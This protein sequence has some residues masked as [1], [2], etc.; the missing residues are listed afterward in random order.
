MIQTN[1][2]YRKTN[3]NPLQLYRNFLKKDP[4]L[5]NLLQTTDYCVVPLRA[6]N[7]NTTDLVLFWRKNGY[8]FVSLH[9]QIIQ[10]SPATAQFRTANWPIWIVQCFLT[11]QDS[12]N[13]ITL[14]NGILSYETNVT[15]Q[16]FR[17][18]GFTLARDHRV[19][20]IWATC[21][22]SLHPHF[23]KVRSIEVMDM[24]AKG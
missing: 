1:K 22:P 5:S 16:S 15:H 18:H 9:G 14:V 3:L 20:L 24:M 17:P 2:L 21:H 23:Y 12:T 19:S 10:S 13:E 6:P 4:K 7:Q 8:M 11:D